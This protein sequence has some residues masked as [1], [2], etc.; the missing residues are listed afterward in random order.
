MCTQVESV[1][2]FSFKGQKLDGS[3]YLSQRNCKPRWYV[4]MRDWD[5]TTSSFIAVRGFA[6][7]V[8]VFRVHYKLCKEK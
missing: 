8:L 4:T 6:G 3:S 5:Q 2:L 1:L 7:R